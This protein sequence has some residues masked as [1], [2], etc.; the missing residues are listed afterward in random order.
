MYH[1]YK[2]LLSVKI[3]VPNIFTFTTEISLVVTISFTA[4][5]V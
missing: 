5:Q 1:V 2:N 4:L 3:I